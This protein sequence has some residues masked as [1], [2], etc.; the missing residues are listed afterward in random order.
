MESPYPIL[1]I[2]AI[3]LFIVKFA[4][5]KFMQ[6]RKPFDLN[7]FTRIYNLYQVISCIYLVANIPEFLGSYNPYK[8]YSGRV[9]NLFHLKVAWFALMLRTSE[10]FETIV[11]VLRKKQNQV[12]WL[13]VYHHIA[14]VTLLWIFFKYSTTQNEVIVIEINSAVHIVMY[15]YYFL[16][17]FHSLKSITNKA[18]PFITAIQITQL[19]IIM[20]HIIHGLARC[21]VSKLYWLQLGNIVILIAMFLQFYFKTYRK[22]KIETMTK[23][24]NP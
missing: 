19:V 2:F 14:V 16:S 7:N 3:Y 17:S 5:P 4:G 11:F 20:T 24:K 6:Y 10:F 22:E 21:D 12:S 18:K 15:S 1:N 8:C 23:I 9:Y 13:H